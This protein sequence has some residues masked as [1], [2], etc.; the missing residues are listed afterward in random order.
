MQKK[1]KAQRVSAI[2][3][4]PAWARRDILKLARESGMVVERLY[5]MV[6]KNGLEATRSLLEEQI[7]LIASLDSGP[8]EENADYQDN[9]ATHESPSAPE[10]VAL[11]NGT[12]RE[13][14]TRTP[15]GPDNA[16]ERPTEPGENKSDDFLDQLVAGQNGGVS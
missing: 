3:A 16:L 11:V 4:P 5:G 6:I 12:Q 1:P 13:E 2:P 9:G 8:L 14:D 7:T 10:P 15:V